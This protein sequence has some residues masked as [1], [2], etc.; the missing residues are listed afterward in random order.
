MPR[1][2][3]PAQSL[4]DHRTPKT[5]GR[6]TVASCWWRPSPTNAVHSAAKMASCRSR[7]HVQVED[8]C[9]L[10]LCIAQHAAVN[11]V[12]NG[13]G[14]LQLEAGPHAVPAQHTTLSE[15]EACQSW[16]LAF[17]SASISRQR[18]QHRGGCASSNA[19]QVWQ[20]AYFSGKGTTDL[21]CCRAAAAGGTT[22][23]RQAE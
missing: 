21:P 1:S 16:S 11:G 18:S 7:T 13:A 20:T 19:Q 22:C 2:Q 4:Q 17:C 12:H 9:L 23:L 5:A 8:G 15:L 6:H 3:E 10:V 14:V